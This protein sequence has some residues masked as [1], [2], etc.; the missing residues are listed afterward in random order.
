[1]WNAMTASRPDLS[2]DLCAGPAPPEWDR[3]LEAAGGSVFQTTFWA[4]YSSAYSGGVPQ[5]LVVRDRVGVVARLLVLEMPRAGE[6][7]IGGRRAT[8]RRLGARLLNT[9]SWRE[10]PVITRPEYRPAAVAAC[11]DAVRE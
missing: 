11:L 3:C 5:Y 8:I 7:V 1:M 10:G 6:S 2:V 9:L 4:E